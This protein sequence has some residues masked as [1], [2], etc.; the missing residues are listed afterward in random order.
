MARPKDALNRRRRGHWRLGLH[1]GE[2]C[3]QQQRRAKG[4]QQLQDQEEFRRREQGESHET[5]RVQ[6]QSRNRDFLVSNLA[7]DE[8]SNDS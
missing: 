3:N 5:D 4:L 2:N 8:A 6:D 7:Q 1:K